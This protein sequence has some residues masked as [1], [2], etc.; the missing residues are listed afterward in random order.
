MDQIFIKA[1]PMTVSMFLLLV[2]STYT[3]QINSCSRFTIQKN[4]SFN[5]DDCFSYEIYPEPQ[6]SHTCV[7][8]C[9]S[10]PGCIATGSDSAEYTSICCT[11]VEENINILA[12]NSTIIH[13]SDYRI[14]L[15]SDWTGTFSP[16]PDDKS[17]FTMKL[18]F[19]GLANNCSYFTGIVTKSTGDCAMTY[20]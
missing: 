18:R 1:L 6:P 12:G 5:I 20:S 3:A 7:Q 13:Q 15:G 8:K 11:L 10:I 14:C 17:P 2:T 16:E 9:H 19:Q 4:A